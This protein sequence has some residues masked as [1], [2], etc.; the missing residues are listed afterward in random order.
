MRFALAVSVRESFS[1]QHLRSRGLARA[2]TKKSR[3]SERLW[4][5]RRWQFPRR[6][7]M[8]VSSPSGSGGWLWGT[9]ASFGRELWGAL[10]SSGELCSG[11]WEARRWQFP[12]RRAMAVSSPSGDGRF[13]A[14][15]L[16][17]VALGGCGQLWKG[18]LGKHAQRVW[19][20]DYRENR[21]S[22]DENSEHS[23]LR[24]P[25][26]IFRM[27]RI[28]VGEA[29]VHAAVAG[30]SALVAGARGKF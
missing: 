19:S 6:R 4:E 11:L 29:A 24:P 7:A 23:E 16:W 27:F 26:E 18:S 2:R 3:S 30:P 13:L 10:G 28:F 14:V 15:G 8:A 22:T 17:G 25:P 1:R 9:V 5:A 21:R 12:R 20:G